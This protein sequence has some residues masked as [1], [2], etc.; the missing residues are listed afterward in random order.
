MADPIL[1][2]RWP[3]TFQPLSRPQLFGHHSLT[4]C[5]RDKTTELRG[6]KSLFGG[7]CNVS[8]QF[9]VVSHTCS[10]ASYSRFSVSFF[11]VLF[12]PCFKMY[13]FLALLEIL[14]SLFNFCYSLLIT[15]SLAALRAFIGFQVSGLSIYFMLRPASK[16]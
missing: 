10:S 4:E 5:R 16:T 1:K 6:R 13:S 7:L 12:M 8:S 11:A 2:Y 15:S 9:A 3:K 14:S